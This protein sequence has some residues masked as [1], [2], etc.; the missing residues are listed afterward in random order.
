MQPYLVSWH[1]QPVV[2]EGG[3]LFKRAVKHLLDVVQPERAHGRAGQGVRRRGERGV[4][5]VHSL[6]V[7][8]ALVRSGRRLCARQMQS[9]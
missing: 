7:V 3:L 9:F 4:D 8:P 2:V 1:W 5:D 6:A